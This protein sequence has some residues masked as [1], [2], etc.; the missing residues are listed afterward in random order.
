MKKQINLV[1]LLSLIPGI[2]L[3]HPG[4]G[5]DSVYA[6]FMHTFTGLD[7]LLVAL[8][9]G[10]WSFK[11][12]DAMRWQL[13]FTFICI[14][15]LGALLGMEGLIFN[16]MET[17]IAASL[18]AMGLLLMMSLPISKWVQLSFAAAFALFH[19]MAHGI[20]FNSQSSMAALGGILTATAILLGIGFL[21]ASQL[22]KKAAWV[23]NTFAWFLLFAGS[24]LLL[25]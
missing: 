10:F 18:M 1:T 2:A 21:T 20:E 7:H 11:L 14:I 13:P 5:L 9:I 4:H 8:S 6:G 17:V 15:T 3:A 23:N 24:Y 19:G 25:S 22:N 16:G 12:G